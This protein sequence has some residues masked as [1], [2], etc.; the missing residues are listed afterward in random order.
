[1]ETSRGALE[2]E[3]NFDSLRSNQLV[4]I[5]ISVRDIVTE[6]FYFTKIKSAK[7]HETLLKEAFDFVYKQRS[8]SEP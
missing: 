4:T 3:S 8:C 2:A 1:M 7:N 6:T 5:L